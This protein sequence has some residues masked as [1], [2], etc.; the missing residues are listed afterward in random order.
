MRIISVIPAKGRST[1]LPGKNVMPFAGKEL[2][3]YSIVVSKKSRYIEETFV[4]TDSEEITEIGRKYGAQ[5]CRRPAALCSDTASTLSVLK[6]TL[7]FILNSWNDKPDIVVTLQP[8]CPLRTATFVDNA[9]EKMV[10]SGADSAVSV[11]DIRIKLGRIE[12]GMFLPE[13]AEGVRKQDIR[14]Q[15]KENGVLYI[16]KAEQIL[17]KGTIFGEKILPI[18]T[19]D[20]FAAA[21]IDTQLDFEV[22]ECL[23]HKNRDMFVDFRGAI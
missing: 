11:S 7:E 19:E 9:I 15:Y 12:N 14:P 5:V 22:A 23:F 13:Y 17:E 20:I 6:H 10:D 2:L 3:Y 1:R 21:N 8:T 4:S 16:T 18:L